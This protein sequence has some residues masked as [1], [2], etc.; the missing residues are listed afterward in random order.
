MK[1]IAVYFTD[2]GEDDYPFSIPLYRTVY[3][4]LAEDISSLDG[5][6][7]VVRGQESYTGNNRFSHAW[8]F[9]GTWFSHM[10]PPDTFDLLWNK[11]NIV[12]DGKGE[13]INHP[14][15]TALC[16]DKWKSYNLFPSLHAKTV[17]VRE[18]EDITS[19]ASNMA[20]GMI[21]GKTLHGF[22]GTGV[23]I[24]KSADVLPKLML[25]PKPIILQEFIDASQGIP[26]LC[27]GLHDLRIIMLNG[28]PS[29]SYIRTPPSGEFTANVSRGGK[30]IEVPIAFI[31]C[32]AL[33]IANLVDEQFKKFHRRLYTVD[34]ARRRDGIW[35]LIEINSKPGFSPKATGKSYPIFYR[36]LA[37]LLLS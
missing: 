22:G 37:E 6:F 2:P 32:E 29:L 16:D 4:E 23:F 18:G 9:D 1:N 17:I 8:C 36:K 33:S 5:A 26:G 3:R 7:W 21:V 24:G 11:G 14:E 25:L 15:L 12:H 20:K 31:P 28:K 34:I 35:K 30:E 19:A 10:D 13:M 27:D